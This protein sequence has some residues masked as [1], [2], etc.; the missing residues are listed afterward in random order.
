MNHGLLVDVLSQPSKIL[1]HGGALIGCKRQLRAPEMFAYVNPSIRTYGW[2]LCCITALPLLRI[3]KKAF[4]KAPTIK[5]IRCKGRCVE[6][7]VDL[8]SFHSAFPL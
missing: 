2:Q 6:T 3:P 4:M 8:W 1:P 5:V 7:P